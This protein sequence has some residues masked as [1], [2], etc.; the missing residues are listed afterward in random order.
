[1][2]HSPHLQLFCLRA[3]S[4]KAAARFSRLSPIDST[5]LRN[6]TYSTFPS[7]RHPIAAQDESLLLRQPPGTPSSFI[8]CNSPRSYADRYSRATRGCR[9]TQLTA[10]PFQPS[11]LP[12][13]HPSQ[14]STSPSR[15]TTPPPST[16][17]PPAVATRTAT[18]SPSPPAPSATSTTPKSP[19]SSPNISTKTKRSVGSSKGRDTS[20]SVM[21]R[22]GG[23]G[24]RSKRGI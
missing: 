13:S 1:M 23:S 24:W 3:A 6:N 22:I 8:P 15:L 5:T 10:P 20:M 18:P 11:P 16:P 21:S 2:S 17:S 9:T 12:R 14:S 7:V 4:S 19:P